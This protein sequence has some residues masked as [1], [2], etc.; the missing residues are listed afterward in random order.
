MPS[1][2]LGFGLEL[3]PTLGYRFGRDDVENSQVDALR[4]IED[5]FAGGAFVNVYAE[6]VLQ[7]KDKLGFEFESLSGG[8]G[9]TIRFGPTYGF[10]PTEK[11][12]FGFGVSAT[13][14]DDD[15]NQTYFG[16]DTDN[17]ARSGF[18]THDAEGGI[19]DV[20]L[21]A[22]ATYRITQSVGITANAGITQLM[23]NAADSPIV[24]DDVQFFGG[25]SVS[26]GF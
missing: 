3:G 26:Y 11:W 8:D 13:Y 22:S 21:S 2:V 17:A 18:A 9:T 4:E 15:Y 6:G 23:G 7:K 5:S 16:V 12:R 10:S 25:L 14:A 20:G 19:K 1:G 24:K